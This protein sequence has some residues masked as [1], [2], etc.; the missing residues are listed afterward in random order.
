MDIINKEQDNDYIIPKISN[1]GKLANRIE[2]N[3][4]DFNDSKVIP[5]RDYNNLLLKF[6]FDNNII[7]NK[8]N[9]NTNVNK[10][11]D[12]PEDI[13]KESKISKTLSEAITK[14]TILLI[15]GMIM[16]LQIFNEDVYLSDSLL[17]DNLLSQYIEKTSLSF[18]ESLFVYSAEE[19]NKTIF[20]K[21][22]SI[23]SANLQATNS[24][25]MNKLM[26]I[27]FSNNT[28]YQINT[29]YFSSSLS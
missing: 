9:I 4:K 2:I 20:F 25:Y 18:N 26:D 6:N 1:D 28:I 24:S 7:S 27:N 13:I 8:T 22:D 15:L 5:N 29:D 14:K 10:L 16:G 3:K 17:Y 11:K 21:S 23:P 12:K 19:N